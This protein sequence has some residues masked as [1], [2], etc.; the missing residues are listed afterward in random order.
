AF[1]ANAEGAYFPFNTAATESAPWYQYN[2]QRRDI[3]IGGS[4]VD[5]MNS[6]NDPRVTIYGDTLDND[7]PLFV[8]DRNY[9]LGTYKE[10]QFILA[11]AYFKTGDQAAAY[12]AYINAIQAD[13][14]E[15]EGL[16][17]LTSG[18]YDAYIGQAEV[19]PGEAALTLDDIMTQKYIAMFADPEVFIDWRRTGIPTLTPN[20]GSEVPRRLPYP[21]QEILFNSN[22]P[23]QLTIFD[24]VGWDVN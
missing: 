24:R 6:L 20:S 8:R 22:T 7:H 1:T 14:Q 18:D 15:L 16:G 19:D 2:E 17:L 13:F 10:T 5:L 12:T 21:E 11:E 23:T 9:P 3:A 4:Y